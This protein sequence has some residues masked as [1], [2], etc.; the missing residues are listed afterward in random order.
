[1]E[2]HIGIDIRI[3][4]WNP[5]TVKWDAITYLVNQQ[6]SQ[7]TEVYRIINTRYPVKATSQDT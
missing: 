4:S 6:F 5:S 2:F 3:S 7:Q 1:M